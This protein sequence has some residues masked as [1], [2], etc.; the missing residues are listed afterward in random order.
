M[1][2]YVKNFEAVMFGKKILFIVRLFILKKNIK[3]LKII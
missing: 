3:T 1:E 2:Q